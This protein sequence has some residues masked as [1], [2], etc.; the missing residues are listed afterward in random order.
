MRFGSHAVM[1][2]T[3]RSD[4]SLELTKLSTTVTS[5]PAS[6]KQTMVCVP[7]YPAPPLIKICLFPVVGTIG[8][9]GNTVADDPTA[10]NIIGDNKEGKNERWR[11]VVSEDETDGNC[12]AAGLL[13][14]TRL[15]KTHTTTTTR[16]CMLQ[17]MSILRKS[18]GN[19][20]VFFVNAM[21]FVLAQRQGL[22][23]D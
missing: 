3:R 19:W 2:C 14:T 17:T 1:S 7:M 16:I 6:N 22:G 9:G 18:G 10:L 5:Y 12:T 4:S 11:E 23:L 15:N 13:A 21:T 20:H 8:T